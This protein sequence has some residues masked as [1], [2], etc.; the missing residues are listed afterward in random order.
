VEGA[1]AVVI[2][3]KQFVAVARLRR[4]GVKDWHEGKEQAKTTHGSIR[5]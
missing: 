1:E 5:F 4:L 3:D 2:D